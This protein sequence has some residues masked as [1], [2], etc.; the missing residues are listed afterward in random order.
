MLEEGFE[1]DPDEWWHFDFGNQKWA[2]QSGRNEAL[3][4]E[5]VDPLKFQPKPQI[6]KGPSHALS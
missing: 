1:N 4:G 6:P 5:V 3:Y 2:V